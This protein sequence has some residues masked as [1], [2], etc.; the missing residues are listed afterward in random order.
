MRYWRFSPLVLSSMLLLAACSA[1]AEVK[2]APD[3]VLPAFLSTAAPRVR[4]AYRFAAAHP[5]DLETV[6][7]YCGCGSMGHT[8]NLSCFVKDTGTNWETITFEE[9]AAGCGI[10]V[11]I[12]QDV[13]RMTSEG[14]QP[15]DIRRA[16]DA[17]YGSFGP[18]TDTPLPNG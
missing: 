9:H 3:S 17:I 15:G 4:D 5:H 14:K 1:P 16:I 6:P 7:C 13:M 2:L 11:D 10:C 12:A 8:S 18:A